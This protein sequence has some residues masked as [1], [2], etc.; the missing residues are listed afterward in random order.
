MV[1][2]LV[3]VQPILLQEKLPL[4]LRTQLNLL[5]PLVAQPNQEVV[6]STD[7]N[8][9]QDLPLAMEITYQC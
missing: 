5:A 3:S 6:Q 4:N 9:P 2:K 1:L 7:G 8:G